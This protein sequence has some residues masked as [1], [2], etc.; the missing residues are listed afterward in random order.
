MYTTGQNYVATE[1]KIGK[2]DLSSFLS[3]FVALQAIKINLKL[4]KIYLD[5]ASTACHT[6]IQKCDTSS[7]VQLLF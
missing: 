5:N 6:V 1:A 2:T 3:I 4:E 7:L